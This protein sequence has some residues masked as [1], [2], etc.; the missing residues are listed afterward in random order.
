MAEHIKVI[1]DPPPSN[2][3]SGE[4]VAER[5]TKI[6]D[7][8]YEIEGLSVINSPGEPAIEL[9]GSHI[10]GSYNNYYW[11]FIHED[12]AHYEGLK[13]F[14]PDLK[15][16]LIDLPSIMVD[17]KTIRPDQ[18]KVYPYLK[19]F[20]D[21]Y[22]QEIFLTKTS[23]VKFEKAYFIP[24]GGDVFK[25]NI[26]FEPHG[27]APMSMVESDEYLSW[28]NA[29]WDKRASYGVVGL[30]RLTEKLK[31][32]IKPSIETTKK[33][34]ISRRDVNARLKQYSLQPGYEHLVEER[35]FDDEFLCGYFEQKGYK[36]VA[37][38]EL[39]YPEQMQL[40]MGATHIAGTVGAGFANLHMCERGT[41]LYELHT[42]P[43]YGFD[44]GYYSRVSGIDYK[45]IDLRDL[46][47]GRALSQEE[48]KKILDNVEV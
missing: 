19:F 28:S 34:F 30:R 6:D 32:H 43:I 47:A 2:E 15:L 33:I 39:S 35:F 17:E 8:L 21:L 12:L 16:T 37:L 40:F 13:I 25:T 24:T 26:T 10:L 44:Y 14:I 4:W 38:E 22:P 5:V 27:F 7:Y 48:M 20:L 31:N 18:E 11:H 46:S 9:S 23:N 36:I 41:K 42:I 45:P 3:V 1:A 29:P